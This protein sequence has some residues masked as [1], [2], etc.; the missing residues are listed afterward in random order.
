MTRVVATIPRRAKD[1]FPF[2]DL[3]IGQGLRIYN[4][5]LWEIAK[6]KARTYQNMH[7]GFRFA[8]MK[9]WETKRVGDGFV[10]VQYLQ[11]VRV[12]HEQSS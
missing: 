4:P 3:G 8:F 5:K 11:I 10:P 2:R 12:A 7:S 9:E 1:R 6:N